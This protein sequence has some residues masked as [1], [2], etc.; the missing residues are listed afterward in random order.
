[1]DQLC[2]LAIANRFALPSP[3][4]AAEPLG[5]GNINDTFLV[6]TGCGTRT[7]LQRVNTDVFSR[8]DQ[9]MA[10]LEVLTAHAARKQ[11]ALPRVEEPDGW[12]LPRLIPCSPADAGRP[13]WLEEQ[14]EVWR[15]LS[16]IDNSVC[17]DTVQ[18]P[19]HAHEVGRALGRFHR[20]I[21]DLPGDQLHDTLEGFHVT[22]RYLE[23]YREVL[24]VARAA[25]APAACPES[26]HCQQF[27]EQRL[28]LVPVLEQ[29]RQAGR[30][31]LCAIH[32]D[33]KVNNVL[34]DGASGKAVALVDLDTVKPGLLHYDIGDCLR[35]GCNR[36]GEETTDLEAV[37]FDLDLCRAIL[38]GY[39]LE[40]GGCL[41]GADVEHLYDA[42]RLLPFELG[43]RFFTDHLA[44][45]VYFKARHRRQN[46]ERALVQFRLTLSIEAQEQPI[47]ALIAQLSC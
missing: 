41:S 31:R 2:L 22:P 35:S 27:I 15:M 13:T 39:L 26:E 38:T 4:T 40:A 10:N 16:F 45:N 24:N 7:V 5:N 12:Q 9:V 21:H 1:M 47:R 30:L 25:G 20:L 3:A 11:E 42:I 19:E 23:H 6:R 46:L 32:G 43:L 33:P 44:G 8:P 17:H 28:E 14:G 29:A 18:S 37:V 36:A 34:L